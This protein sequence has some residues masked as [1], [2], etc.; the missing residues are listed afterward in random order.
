M[1]ALLKY[2]QLI[3]GGLGCLALGVLLLIQKGETRHWEKQSD[4]YQQLYNGEKSSFDT[5]VA[6]YRTKAAQAQASD[7]ANKTAVESAQAT[8]NQK[9]I[10]DLQTRLAD[11]S[12]EY[13]RLRQTTSTSATN[14]SGSGKPG[15]PVAAANQSAT[16]CPANQDGFSLADRYAATKQAIQLDELIKAVVGIQNAEKVSTK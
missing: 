7:L 14:S 9:V 11:A 4:Q 3:L 6:D 1:I 8:S 13:Q 2:W 15:V 5:T 16:T 12:A 10:N